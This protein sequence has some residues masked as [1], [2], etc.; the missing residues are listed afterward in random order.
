MHFAPVGLPP[1]ATFPLP[2]SGELD[3]AGCHLSVH[4]SSVG[5][6]RQLAGGSLCWVS[7]CN[8]RQHIDT[9]PGVQTTELQCM[10]HG[11][12][13]ST[14]SSLSLHDLLVV[15]CIG[16]GLWNMILGVE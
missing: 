1:P 10:T 12:L 14:Y 16:C 9:T 15:V 5:S 8:A 3:D 6:E 13:D 2:N 4:S 11:S 7:S